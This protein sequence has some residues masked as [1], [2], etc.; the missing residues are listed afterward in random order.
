V[1]IYNDVDFIR[2]VGRRISGYGP[3]RSS[4]REK[5]TFVTGADKRTKN[6]W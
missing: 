2:L 6:E 3:A 1:T 5:R 4:T